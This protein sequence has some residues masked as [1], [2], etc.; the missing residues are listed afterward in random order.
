MGISKGR[1]IAVAKKM[2]GRK[3]RVFVMTGDGELQ[4]GQIFEALQATA[5]QRVHDLT[6]I[7]DHNKLQSDRL[8]SQI[9]DLGDLP[10]KFRAFGWHVARCDGHDS[11]QLAA[12]FAE[13]RRV[14]DKPRILI[15]DTIKGRGVSFMEHPVALE[16]DK[17]S[18]RWH[19]GA[20]DDDSFRA[21]HAELVAR[22]NAGMKERGLGEVGLEDVT[23]EA[24]APSG[25]SSELVSEHF[26][27]ALV[28]IAARRRDLVVLDG[29]L[30]LDCKIRKFEQTYPDRFIENGIAEQDMVSMAGGLALQGLLPVVNTFANFLTARANEQIYNNAGERTKVIYAAHFGGLLPAGPGKS[31]Q[32]TRDV[33][34][35]GAL[36]NCTVLEPANG[37]ETRMAVEYC[38]EEARESC[39]LRLIIGPSPRVVP[40][41]AGYRL[42]FGR[43]AVLTEGRDAILFSYGP[44][45]LHEALL[46]SE[47]LAREGFGLAVVNMPWLNRVD[48]GW[49]KETV[50]GLRRVYSLDDHSPYGG[51]GDSL[52][53]ALNEEGLLASLV[54]RKMGIREIPACG[55]PFEVLRHHGVDSETIARR[56]KNGE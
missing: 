3:G 21:A 20:P 15:A 38:V 1:G 14:E 9:T 25:V 37:V 35:L 49:L 16:K 19:A 33:S 54:F 10:A 46:A 28:E 13:L 56:I 7:V 12:S 41:P 40:L 32:A 34:L 24:K 11:G 30:A 23:P 42:R 8:V 39:V 51:L 43:G 44:V 45:M 53:N 22:I 6:V 31:H 50:A 5:H 52:L 4:E 2:L 47:A 27:A 48:R 18:Y 29:D 55:A 26:G 36:P 17:G